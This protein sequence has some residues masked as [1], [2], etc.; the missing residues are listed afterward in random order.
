M[1]DGRVDGVKVV[2][3]FEGSA[4]GVKDGLTVGFMEG[5]DVGTAE[6]FIDGKV[7][8]SAVGACDGL[9]VGAM[10]GAY[11]GFLDRLF[12]GLLDGTVDEV[13]LGVNVAFAVGLVGRWVGNAIGEGDK[14]LLAFDEKYGVN[15][16]VLICKFFKCVRW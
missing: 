1:M 6:G 2:G 13:V 12:E 14:S 10:D 9:V 11:E 16:N 5:V 15:F 4:D 7:D 8:G 3:I